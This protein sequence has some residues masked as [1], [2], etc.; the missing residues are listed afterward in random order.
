MVTCT[1][2]GQTLEV[3][4]GTTILTAASSV[5]IKIPTFCFHERLSLSA[6]C[7]MCLVEVEGRGKLEPAC[8]TVIAPDMVIHTQS[9]QV[10]GTRQDMLE[11]LLANHPLDCPVCDKG[12][13]CELQDT[14]FRYGKGDSRL[15]DP[16][17]VF[18]QDDIELNQV[19]VFN[20]NRCIQ[21][22]R[23]VRVCEEVVGDVALG[24]SERGL[25]SEITGV[26]NSLKDCSHCGNCIEVCPVGAL[27]SIPYRYKARP[28]D[29]EKTETICG[30]CGSGCSISVE[31]ADGRFKRVK[32]DPDTGMN[33]ELL[34]AKGRFG[35]DAIDGGKRIEHPMIRKNGV[36]K[37]VGWPEAIQLI[38]TRA[39]EIKERHGR[40]QGQISPRQSNETAYKFQQLMRRVFESQDIHSSTR[41]SGLQAPGAVA[42]LARL[43]TGPMQRKPLQSLLEADCIF[44]LGANVSEENPV[45]GYLL[46]SAMIDSGKRLIV[47]SS[48]PSGLD[49]IASAKL[50]LLPGKE[51]S[52]MSRLISDA[53][54]LGD[55]PKP[56]DNMIAKARGILNGAERI[57]LLI[58]T[59]FLRTSKAAECLRWIEKAVGHFGAQG[60]TVELQFLFDRPNQLG[61]WDMGC[62]SGVAP[63]WQGSLTPLPE[64][65][66]PVE[67]HYILGA[68]PLPN[69]PSTDRPAF[70]VVH[71]SHFNKT[72]ERADVVLPSASYGEE[73]GTYTNNEGRV[74]TLRPVR[75]PLPD[76]LAARQ[77]FNLISRAMWQGPLPVEEGSVRNRIK[78]K[79]PAFGLFDQETIQSEAGQTCIWPKEDSLEPPEDDLSQGNGAAQGRRH[80]ITGDNQFQSGKLA[81]RSSILSSLDKGP[82][83]EM[84]PGAG[85]D[86][87]YEGM[88]VTL[89]S[90][91]ESFT[92]P[93]R[94][95]RNL[96]EDTVFVPESFLMEH[97]K[98]ILSCVDYPRDVDVVL[99]GFGHASNKG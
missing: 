32:S 88:M 47:S 70:L 17:R 28:W 50:R 39:C 80:L 38:A 90:T 9:A 45:S 22:Q 92:A 81:T 93:L 63:G 5:G 73:S 16:K 26:G 71:T 10:A 64:P 96:D 29:L 66:D 1:M 58:G 94:I 98:K 85:A 68:D 77:V 3:D 86:R 97:G 49:A 33:K 61:L 79:Y 51:A 83:V 30:M 24:T 43:V 23:C 57:T 12:G 7:R 35:F 25:D 44:L 19:I 53:S 75:S 42:A 8:A 56:T 91:G 74:Q 84:N 37:P 11:I 65:E 14:V 36:L 89:F 4:P 20:A 59:E 54:S 62:L 13:E 27:M 52:L 67:L 60:K 48:R 82:Y 99:S 15:R 76:L 55:D 21:C 2:D 40:I 18:R 72:V 87:E 78:A 95:N 34:C 31:F 69:E 46:R 6:S 41:F